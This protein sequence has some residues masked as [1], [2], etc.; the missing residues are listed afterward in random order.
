MM[1]EVSLHYGFIHDKLSGSGSSIRI[2]H[3]CPERYCEGVMFLSRCHIFSSAMLLVFSIVLILFK[4][5]PNI[6][7]DEMHGIKSLSS[8][9]GP[10]LKVN[11]KQLDGTP[12]RVEFE[13]IIIPDDKETN[14]DSPMVKGDY[15]E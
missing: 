11:A 14:D 8:Q 12:K 1:E 7:G 13:R 15:E 5:I 2:L 4:D 3:T 9:I 6:E 10:E